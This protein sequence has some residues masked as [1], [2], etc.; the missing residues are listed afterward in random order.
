MAAA[1]AREMR[2]M[3]KDYER[4]EGDRVAPVPRTNPKHRNAASPPTLGGGISKFNPVFASLT[5]FDPKFARLSKFNPRHVKFFDLGGFDF[6]PRFP[7]FDSP[8]AS[9][10]QVKGRLYPA[11]SLCPVG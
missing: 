8:F 4:R 5:S 9:Q 10:I 3:R 6:F 2:G 1:L 11:L 7:Y